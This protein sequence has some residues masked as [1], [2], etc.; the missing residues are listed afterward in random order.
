MPFV[1]FNSGERDRSRSLLCSQQHPKVQSAIQC[2]RADIVTKF[3]PNGQEIPREWL[4]I[5]RSG[6]GPPPGRTCH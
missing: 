6:A 1:C 2:R 4:T 5:T 3:F